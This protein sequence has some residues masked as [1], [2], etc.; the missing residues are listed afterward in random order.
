MGIKTLFL[1]F[2]NFDFYTIFDRYYK[3]HVIVIFFI[4]GNIH[5]DFDYFCTIFDYFRVMN[6]YGKAQVIFF[7]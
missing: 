7:P 3:A 6:F 1:A 5:F 2:D 4:F